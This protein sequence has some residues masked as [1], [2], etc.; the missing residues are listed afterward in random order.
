V[1]K[2][3][4]AIA[5]EVAMDALLA[6]LLHIAVEN[7]GAERGA[8][9]L[10]GE[11]G[12]QVHVHPATASAGAGQPLA[13]SDAVPVGV[14]HYVR[15]TATPLVLVQADT[16]PWAG[17]AYMQRHRPRSLACVPV[18]QQGRLLAVLVLEHRQVAAAF[19]PARLHTLQV[20]A[21]QAAI[22]LE[23]ARL[24]QGLQ[25]QVAERERAQ[26]E[27]AA[28]L[29][30]VQQLSADLQ[31]ENH[32]LRRD[33]V[34]NVSHD[35]RTPLAALRGYLEVL[36]TRGDALP[37]AQRRQHLEVALR[38]SESLST[39]VDELFE[40]AKLDFRGVALQREPFSFADLASDVLQK[41]ELQAQAARV[42]LAVE[43]PAGL[44]PVDAD[45]GLIERVLDNLVGNALRHTPAGGRVGVQLEAAAGGLLARVCDSG[46]GIAEADLPHI[47]DRYYR[48]SGQRATGAGLGL[49]ITRR[50]L[51][52]HGTAVQVA[53]DSGRG[54][55]FSFTLPLAAA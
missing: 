47:F 25:L 35:L 39:L 10:E 37:A 46:C 3:A 30:R 28:A 7:A 16:E 36:A 54:T 29:A 17:D 14:V 22:S 1:L 43:A 40:L 32:S 9:V 11:G 15:R 5:G 50:I 21:T 38:Q 45:P 48:G 55:C 8:L 27:L 18:G 26:G 44:P 34:A 52:L 23:N 41:F 31:A 2:A 13:Q 42:T 20:L 24:V 49:A 51:E 19:T 4:Q 12:P 6:R 33:L 53:S